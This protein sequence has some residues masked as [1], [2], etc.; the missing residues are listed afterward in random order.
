MSEEKANSWMRQADSDIAFAQSAHSNGFFAQC[1]FIC[2]Q[3]SEKALKSIAYRHGAQLV[4]GHSL[5]KLC[6][7]L[8]INGELAK[9]A[10]VLDQYYLSSRYPDSLPSGAPCDVFTQE[11]A[12][13]AL[14]MAKKFLEEAKHTL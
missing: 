6:A 12:E 7:E 1:C 5:L 9:A 10:G 14:A 8:D 3:A 11:Q 13:Q 2:Q 4:M